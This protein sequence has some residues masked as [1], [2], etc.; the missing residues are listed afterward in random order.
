MFASKFIKDVAE[1]I[2][3]AEVLR[4]L[5]PVLEGKFSIRLTPLSNDEYYDDFIITVKIKD[6]PPLL[7][8]DLARLYD[9]IQRRWMSSG[10][11]DFMKIEIKRCNIRLEVECEVFK[12]VKHTL[13]ALLQFLTSKVEELKYV[14]KKIVLDYGFRN[15]ASLVADFMAFDEPIKTYLRTFLKNELRDKA[16]LELGVCGKVSYFKAKKSIGDYEVAV[17]SYF[18]V[19]R[20]ILRVRSDFSSLREIFDKFVRVELA[21][22][23]ISWLLGFLSGLNERDDLESY[24]YSLILL[25]ALK[26]IRIL[27]KIAFIE[28]SPVKSED[29]EQ[30]SRRVINLQAPDD[31]LVDDLALKHPNNDFEY[32]RVYFGVKDE[33]VLVILNYLRSGIKRSYLI[34]LNSLLRT[35]K[36]LQ[37]YLTVFPLRGLSDVGTSKVTS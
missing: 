28:V 22:L 21:E 37:N 4:N 15:F 12:E 35:K 9:F 2:G 5:L 36:F 7:M 33:Y 19:N 8:N 27:F 10:E 11:V 26:D 23:S 6:E 13:V 32:P 25:H 1:F 20:R 24:I 31:F 14:S 29:T 3:K 17:Y 18:L 30:H 16:L 34:K